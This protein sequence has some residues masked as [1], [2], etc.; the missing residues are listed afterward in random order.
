MRPAQQVI[1][2]ANA[3]LLLG[4]LSVKTSRCIL[5]L[6]ENMQHNRKHKTKLFPL[7]GSEMKER[8]S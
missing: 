1:R 7:V 3:T 4:H 2:Y 5:K 8:A 6:R